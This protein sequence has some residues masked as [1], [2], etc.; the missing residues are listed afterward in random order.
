MKR[1]T[2]YHAICLSLALGSAWSGMTITAGAQTTATPMTADTATVVAGNNEFALDLYSQLQTKPG[3]LFFSPY[4]ISIAL[5]MASGGAH[6]ETLAQMTRTLHL[7]LPAD[8]L[9]PAIAA[10]TAGLDA[11]QEKGQV[12]LT[13]ANSLWPQA[14]LTILPDYLDLCARYYQTT[15][16]PVDYRQPAA[17]CQ[18]I[19][20]WVADKTND[21]ITDLLNPEAVAGAKLTLVNAIYFKGRW[22]SPFKTNLTQAAPFHLSTG[23][24]VTTPLMHQTDRFGYAEFPG[25]QVL[26]LPYIGN[27][28]S[29]LVLLPRET[30][31][32]DQFQAGLT[33]AN[34]AV[35]T[36]NLVRQQV[37]VFLPKFKSTSQFSLGQTLA[38]M[39]MPDAF[40]G[41]ADFSGMDG[42]RD[43]FIS[44]VV[45]KA[46]VDVYEEGTEAAA[47]TGVI[48]MREAIFR[49]L[50]PPPIFRADH[51]FLF[52][53]RD[54][55]TGS[56][57]FLGRVTNPAPG[58]DQG[59]SSK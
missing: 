20:Q 13:V 39:G 2:F 19:N 45:H 27:D 7:D 53:I 56:I 57:L 38:A 15:I 35:W 37:E 33:M 32:L 11:V 29:M 40:D 28:V 58:N 1:K 43:L 31:R 18:I 22:T 14:G 8:R 10:V 25:L 55:H 9:P 16:T 6:G 42:K 46:F 4:S 26:E 36:T 17:A 47:A 49:P 12:K 50:N 59:V 23:D 44:D 48:M 52:L 5:A 30:N 51:P 24:T 34:L 41:Q 54:N 3:N 21:K